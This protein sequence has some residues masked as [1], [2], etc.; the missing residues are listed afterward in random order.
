MGIES[1]TEL[2]LLWGVL[3]LISTALAIIIG[4][5]V[6]WKYFS[7]RRVEVISAGFMIIFAT[8]GWWVSL[9]SIWIYI[10]FGIEL[11]LETWFLFQAITPITTILWIYTFTYLLYPKS[12]WKIVGIIV[13]ITLVWEIF[14]II[15]IFTDPSLIGTKVSKF[16]LQYSFFVFGFVIFT[17]IISIITNIIFLRQSLI[18][19]SKTVRWRGIFIF[20]STMLFIIG[21]FLDTGIPLNPISLLITRSILFLSAVFAYF[22]WVMPDWIKR[23]LIKE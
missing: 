13:A 16:D 3:G 10:F 18:S 12:K 21:A 8:S 2:E 11:P 15:Y 1:V 17:L 7:S 6:I 22:G 19:D 4:L 14:F 20:T 5:K 9:S 23:R